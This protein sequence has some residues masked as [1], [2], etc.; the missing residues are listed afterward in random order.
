[1]FTLVRQRDAKDCGPSCLAM[2]VKYYGGSFN[3][4]SIRTDCAL[5]REGVSLLGISKAAEEL[6][7]KSVGGRLSFSSLASEALLPCIVHW[8]QNHFV[9]VYKVK[10]QKKG[11]A[12]F[13]WL[14][15]EKG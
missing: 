2:I 15:Q 12:L 6:G 3:I 14:I 5:N 13:M 4:N 10:N 7:F 11:I 1:M 9:V 8:S